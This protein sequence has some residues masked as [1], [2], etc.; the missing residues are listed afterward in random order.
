MRHRLLEAQP[1]EVANVVELTSF[2]HAGS[3]AT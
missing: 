1:T 2:A 3:N